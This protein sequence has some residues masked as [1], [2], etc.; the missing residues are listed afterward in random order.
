[1]HKTIAGRR[2]SAGVLERAQPDIAFLEDIS[3]EVGRDQN[4]NSNVELS[5]LD[6][7]GLLQIF[8]DQK[9]VSFDDGRALGDHP[10]VLIAIEVDIFL[11]FADLAVG[12]VSQQD[13]LVD[14]LAVSFYIVHPLRRRLFCDL[15]TQRLLHIAADIFT[16]ELVQG[17]E[18][19]KDL[20]APTSVE[21]GRLDDP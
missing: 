9:A 10:D 13:R 1:M 5:L 2:V 6:Q 19:G 18:L 11:L 21:K 15:C 7:H 4:P 12:W 16:D 14:L 8:L 20:D 3:P 17:F